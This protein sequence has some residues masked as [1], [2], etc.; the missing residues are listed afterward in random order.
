MKAIQI[1]Q[2]GGP[3]VMKLKEVQ[4]PK[5][6]RDQI[7][8]KVKAAGVNPVDLVFRSGK[9][10]LVK[11]IKLPWIPGL[12]VSGEIL[13]V[14]EGVSRFKVGD[15]VMGIV[16][17]GGYAEKAVLEER[18]TAHLPSSYS[19]AEGAS[20]PVVLFTAFYALINKGKIKPG[21]TVLIQAG[22]GGVGSMAIQIAKACHLKVFTTVSS[23][24][25]KKYCKDIGADVV[26]N[27][28]EESFSERCLKE[29]GGKGVDLLIETVASE[30]FEEDTKAL[31]MFGKL[32]LIGAGTGKN[33]EGKILFP[34][35]YS[36]DITLLGMSLFNAGPFFPEMVELVENLL[37]TKAI[38]PLVGKKLPLNQ[39]PASHELLAKGTTLGKIVLEI[40]G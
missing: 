32:V 11:N 12:D 37:S 26:I 22:A 34:G 29:T 23:E 5:L 4:D 6:N 28:R 36:K 30:N 9:H 31:K 2:F 27:Y 40:V 17:W 7:L 10:P 14:G 8:I 19:F 20:M 24:E 16:S 13:E 18:K 1:D 15:R 39:A 21:Q 35:F 33:P 3:E 38:K 25:K